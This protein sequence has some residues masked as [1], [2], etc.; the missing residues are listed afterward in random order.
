MRKAITSLTGALAF[1]LL[2]VGCGVPVTTSTV[3]IRIDCVMNGGK[4]PG[5]R[6]EFLGRTDNRGLSYNTYTFTTAAITQMDFTMT[7]LGGLHKDGVMRCDFTVLAPT[8]KGKD[9]PGTV[10]GHK[11]INGPHDRK[12]ETIHIVLVS[13]KVGMD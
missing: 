12:G 8:A 10:L 13:G 4:A 3:K 7:P 5:Y 6:F 2:L 1:G 11:T 9:A